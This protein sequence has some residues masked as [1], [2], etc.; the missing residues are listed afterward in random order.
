MYAWWADVALEGNSQV[1]DHTPVVRI[2][3]RFGVIL[4]IMSE[5]M[6]FLG[7]V[8]VVL[9]AQAIYPM[10]PNGQYAR[11]STEC[12]AACRDTRRFS[13]PATSR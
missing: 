5:V 10:V 11:P 7:L 2:G 8:L 4:F 9:Q 1:G 12:V 13:T 6:F 3:L